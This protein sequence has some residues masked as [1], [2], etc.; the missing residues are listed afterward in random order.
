[1][2][3]SAGFDKSSILLMKRPKVKKK[4]VTAKMFEGIIL[5]LIIVSSI[6]LVIDNPLDDPESASV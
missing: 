2:K 5:S 3:A 6:T 1:M 4:N